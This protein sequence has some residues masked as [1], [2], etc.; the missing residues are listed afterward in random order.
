[1]ASRAYHVAERPPT[2]SGRIGRGVR[3]VLAA[4]QRFGTMRLVLAAVVI[5]GVSLLMVGLVLDGRPARNRGYEILLMGWLGVLIPSVAWLANLFFGIAVMRLG[6]DKTAHVPAWIAAV[7]SL[8]TFRVFEV[9]VSAAP[10][11]AAVLGYGWGAVLWVT[12][13]FV[14]LAAAGVRQ[15]E[16]EVPARG[17]ASL[18]L[19]VG[20]TGALLIPTLAMA[21][22]VVDRAMAS[23]SEARRLDGVAFKRGWVCS[24]PD[25]TP[26]DSLQRLNGALE[27]I[28]EA[29]QREGGSRTAPFDSVMK[30]LRWGIPVVRF[31]G[32]DHTLVHGADVMRAVPASGPIGARLEVRSHDKSISLVLVSSPEGRELVRQTWVS[33]LRRRCPDYHSYPSEVQ[34]PRKV[35][36]SA[37][38][39]DSASAIDPPAPPRVDRIPV[40]ARLLPRDVRPVDPRYA[41]ES[42]RASL[43]VQFAWNVNCP[44]D[45]GWRE[46]SWGVA[47]VEFPRAFHLRDTKY[48]PESGPQSIAVCQGND[49]YLFVTGRDHGKEYFTVAKR[50]LIDFTPAWTLPIAYSIT[51]GGGEDGGL[52]LERVHEGN[53]E[54][55][56]DMRYAKSGRE[57]TAVVS[58]P[59]P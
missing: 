55:R 8:D 9:P 43:P 50:S 23:T 56:V 3:A 36:V 45:I 38:N 46:R 18:G 12:S 6:L 48:Y 54:L 52:V 10:S 24:R 14:L 51:T 19:I 17:S 47:A 7:L 2:A 21:K 33:D 44:G 4:V 27:L 30:L 39:I 20:A 31:Q 53:K 59:F 41:R 58:L 49:V 26:T 42:D 13:M 16:R 40:D 22:A 28:V 15:G 32:E 25:P 57:V 5:W 1:M 37:L 11:Y 29:G 34:Q 35:L